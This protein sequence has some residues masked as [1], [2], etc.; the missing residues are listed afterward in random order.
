MR[1][2]VDWNRAP[3]VVP[4]WKLTTLYVLVAALGAVVMITTQPTLQVFTD[5]ET[6]VFAWAVALALSALLAS[7][8]STAERFESLERWGS[9][10]LSVLL[11]GYAVISVIVFVQTQNPDRASF[12]IISLIVSLVPSS[13]AVDLLR[14]TGLPHA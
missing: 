14:A 5:S 10:M 13:R 1:K 3:I 7:I 4:R 11:L 6:W 9:T 12:A 8:G 2:F